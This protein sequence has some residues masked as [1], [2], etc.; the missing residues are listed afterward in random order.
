MCVDTV[1]FGYN[2]IA[3]FSRVCIV[4]HDSPHRCAR[5]VRRRAYARRNAPAFATSLA[6]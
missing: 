6:F 4:G 3:R 5:F 1:N 2:A